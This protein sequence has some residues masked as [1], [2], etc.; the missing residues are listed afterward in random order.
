MIRLFVALE[1]PADV[2]QELVALGGGVPGARWISPENMH[3]TLR[4]IGE[5]NEGQ[6]ADIDDALTAVRARAF[7]LRLAGVNAFGKGRSLHSLWVGVAEPGPVAALHEK[8]DRVLQEAGVAPDKRKFHP[9]V[10]LARLR[11]APTD[12][13][14]AF[15]RRHAL[16]SAGPLAI[17]RFVLFSS[18]LSRNGSIYRNEAEYELIG[19]G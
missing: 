13:V 4:F 16:F 11:D 2:R 14:E 5:V 10:T 19:R 15:M 3:L 9:H 6:A 7:D 8:I 18:H 1:L 12:R 17:D